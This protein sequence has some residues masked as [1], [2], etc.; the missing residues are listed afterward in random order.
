MITNEEA[1]C[2]INS[3]KGAFLANKFDEAFDKLNNV[4]TSHLESL[5]SDEQVKKLA[6]LIEIVKGQFNF[7]S[8]KAAVFGIS[9]GD[10]IVRAKKLT[11]GDSEDL[12]K[13]SVLLSIGRS[14]FSSSDNSAELQTIFSDEFSNNT[15]LKHKLSL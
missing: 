3:I 14:I 8:R 12:R 11:M 7:A 13:M 6:E 15:T 4:Y 10:K 1:S 5:S 2:L 9:V